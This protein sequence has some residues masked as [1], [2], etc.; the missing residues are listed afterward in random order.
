MSRTQYFSCLLIL[1]GG[2]SLLIALNRPTR[3]AKPVPIPRFARTSLSR[4]LAIP[5][6]FETNVGQAEPQ[7]AFLARGRHLSTF[8]TRTGIEVEPRLTG[9]KHDFA[10]LSTG[11]ALKGVS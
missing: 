5:L 2:A 6:T 3:S 10:S 4:P 11:N 1:T 9:N 8:L 7:V